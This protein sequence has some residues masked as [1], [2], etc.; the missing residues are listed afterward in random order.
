MIELRKI[1]KSF[2]KNIHPRVYFQSATDKAEYPYIVFDFPAYNDD[3]EFQDF[4]IIDI[5]GWDRPNNGDTTELEIL[6]KSINALNKKTLMTDDWVVSFYLDRKLPLI[7]PDPS[8]KR[9]K[10]VYQAKLYK[11]E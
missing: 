3:G 11:R 4:V 6:M 2:I 1:L 7:D 8:I 5:D 10:Y 9:R